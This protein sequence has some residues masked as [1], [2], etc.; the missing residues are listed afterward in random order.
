MKITGELDGRALERKDKLNTSHSLYN[1][2]NI[3]Y[4]YYII[5]Y[6][7]LVLYTIMFLYRVGSVKSIFSNTI[8][9]HSSN[10]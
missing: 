4:I 1:S 9:T 8:S 2:T 3:Y 10:I 5:Y 6:I 7:L